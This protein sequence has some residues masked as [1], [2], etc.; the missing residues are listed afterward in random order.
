MKATAKQISYLMH[1]LSKAGYSTRY[2][3]A[4]FK[5]LGASMQERSGSVES[6]LASRTVSEASKLI[7]Q[8]KG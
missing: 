7:D 8:L 4:S 2:M 1:L 5:R 6:W 3:D